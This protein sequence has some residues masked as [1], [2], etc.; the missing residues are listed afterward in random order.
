MA[1][2]LVRHGETALNAALVVQPPDTPLNARGIEQARR[3]SGRLA[4]EPLGAI[5]CS[6]LLRAR[7]TAEPLFERTGLEPEYS[8][9]LQERNLG[10]H[11]GTPYA[12]LELDIF[13]QQY[14]PPEGESWIR[15]HARTARAWRLI[16]ERAR[17]VQGHLVVITHGLVCRSLAERQLS[18]PHGMAVPGRWGNTSLTRI[19]D[20]PP[21]R[22]ELVNCTAHL[23]TTSADGQGLS[24][25]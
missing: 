1:I 5:L 25:L 14:E 23:D 10:V 22:V 21:Y 20:R 16:V 15:F 7:M 17:G 8:A 19:D 9:E 18:F 13:A 2:L 3:L 11:R 24:G 6:D 12:E 4:R